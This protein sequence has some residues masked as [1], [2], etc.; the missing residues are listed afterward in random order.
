M[1]SATATEI[2]T[3][4]SL[5]AE[6]GELVA[7]CSAIEMQTADGAAP[8]W[9]QL[10]PAGE[11]R[12][13]DNRG[14]Y[15]ALGGVQALIQRS[16]ASERGML[17]DENH[18][19]DVAA[20]RGEPAPARGWIT[21][22]EERDGAVW[23]KV[24]WN[25]AGKQLMAEKAY[26][27]ISPVI[28][29]TAAGEIISIARASLVNKPNLRGMAALHQ[30]ENMNLLAKLIAALGLNASTSEDAL[31]AAVTSLHAETTQATVA[32]QAQLDPIA[33]AAGLKK[34]A[35]A[36]EVLTAIGTLKAGASDDTRIVALQA[37]LTTVTNTLNSLTESTARDKAT[38]FI[39]G[40]IASKRVGVAPLRD[41]YISRHMQDSAA[42]EKEIG[43]MPILGQSH[44]AITPPVDKAGKGELTPAQKAT[45]SLMGISEEAY[46]K[47]L[48]DEAQAEAA[49]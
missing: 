27:F 13:N 7:L 41:H 33:E 15:R 28:I 17:L 26:R 49:L 19:T 47:T 43:A 39:D 44:T 14:P 46:K 35:K 34:G 9:V 42:V 2:G 24:D 30:E 11:I 40:A 36:D 38:A 29:H 1:K 32:L 10:L 16:L 31:V 21:G 8:E 18:S 12:T 48:A 5:H 6:A 25:A 4:V 45:V 20:P 3:F 22:L 37:E 23:G